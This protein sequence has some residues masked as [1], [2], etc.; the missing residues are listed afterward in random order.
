MKKKTDDKIYICRFSKNVLSKS[1][2]IESSK[3]CEQTVQ[4]QIKWLIQGCHGQGNN[5]ENGVY[6]QV[7][8]KSAIFWMAREI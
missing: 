5:L 1:C 4:I 8:E 2:H 3:R 6:F 7:R